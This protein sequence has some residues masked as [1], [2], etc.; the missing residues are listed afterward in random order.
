MDSHLA[1]KTVLITEAAGKF[2]APTA[3]GFAREG[4]NLALG[5]AGPVDALSPTIEAAAELGVRVFT[6]TWDVSN[7]EQVGAFVSRCTEELGGLDVVVNNPAVTMAAESLEDISFEDWSRKLGVEITGTTF[8]CKAAL[9]GM[10][11]QGWG[12][13]INY[14]GLSGF[15]GTNA[16]DAAV[17]LGMVGLA[18]GIAREYGRHNITANC[19]GPGGIGPAEELGVLPIPPSERDGVTRWGTPDELSFLAVCLSSGDA[20]YVTGQTLLANGGKFF[21]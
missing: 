17:D 15:L 6:G 10:I 11:D 13:I 12:R 19:I 3:L 18:R 14:V 20:G 9:P 7:E 1:G 16:P 21:L 8:V 2:G 4:C 5:T